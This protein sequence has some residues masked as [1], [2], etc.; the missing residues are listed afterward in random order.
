MRHLLTTVL[1]VGLASIA[2]S[3]CGGDDD[4]GGGLSKEDYIAQADAICEEANKSETDSGVPPAGVPID[5]P[6]VQQTLV[7]ILRDTVAD[8]RALKAPEGEEA[9]AA[10]VISHLEAARAARED[11]F[12]ASRAKDSDAESKAENE[13]F[14]ASQ[15][16]G[17]SAGA[18]GLTHC[19][20]L[21]F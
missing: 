15:D 16:L 19:Q 5:D 11:Q 7:T 20:A 8:L 9:D 4:D 14:T 10:K 21:G 3:A 2:T 18:F 17:A 6:E 1:V 12:A 13:F